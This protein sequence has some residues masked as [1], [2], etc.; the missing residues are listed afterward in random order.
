MSRTGNGAPLE[1]RGAACRPPALP[2]ARCGRGGEL[3]APA[4][5]L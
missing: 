4:S 5:Q 2:A 1:E 3:L